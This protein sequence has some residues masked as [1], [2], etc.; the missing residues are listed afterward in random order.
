MR[1][2]KT[3]VAH[4]AGARPKRL[5]SR[6]GPRLLAAVMLPAL[7]LSAV[8]IAGMQRMNQDATA[9][10][11]VVAEVAQVERTLRLYAGLVDEKSGSES[12][13]IASAYNLS[14]AQV[15]RLT[16]F[17]V[18][19]Q[20]RTAR[21]AVDAALA[22]GGAAILGKHA[23]R[24]LPLRTRID[25]GTAPETAVRPYFINI[26]EVAQS[27]WLA[28]IRDLTQMSL[29]TVRAT[30][31]R[32]AIAGLADA[33]DAFLAG[34]RMTWASA[35]LT[36]QG[37]PGGKTGA[38]DLAAASALYARATSELGTELTGRGAATWH[39]LIAADADVKSFQRFLA[40]LRRQP[41]G[42]AAG[43]SIPEVART[44]RAGLIFQGHLRK[45]VDAAAVDVRTL[46]IRLHAAT[47]RDRNRY[48]LGLALVAACTA[49][50][51]FAIARSIVTPLRR[52]AAR[53]SEVSAG[54]IGDAPLEPSGPYEVALVTEAFNE[55][56]ANLV[57]LDTI[58]LAFADAHLDDPVLVNALPGRLGDSLRDS[59]ETLKESIR[60][61]A[62]LRENLQ[63]SETHFRDL[64][65]R[66]PD[67]VFRLTRDPAPRL[68]YL[69]PSF[70]DLT[71]ISV[72]SA[73]A[74]FGIV[75]AALDDLGRKVLADAA[76][77]RNFKPQVDITLRRKD[78]T[79]AV[80]E[81]H[82]VE[83]SDGIH[84]IGRD[85]TEIRALQAVLAEQ[86]MR[87]P[88][89]GLANRRF[90]DELLDRSL[91]R[92]RR[93]GTPIAVAFLDLDAFKSVNDN[94]GHEAGDTVLRVTAARLQAAVRDADVVARYGGDEFIVVYEGA[95]DDALQ[96][97]RQCIEDALELPVDI[98]NGVTVSCRPSVGIADSRVTHASAAE[99]ID[100]A[101]RAMLEAKRH[102]MHTPRPAV[103]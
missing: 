43:V 31:I 15:A 51:A 85:V 21:A 22:D 57:A 77:G 50:V 39:R 20:L 88:L 16:G 64:A 83:T 73:M 41:S 1:P 55:V 91:R 8:G 47:R 7:A 33:V 65:D 89:T 9:V 32:R 56:V 49:A 84:G 90:L 69:S 44:F 29:T 40:G 36:T 74:D 72:A 81:L 45:V 11:A 93:A 96:R 38:R 82:V 37:V 61:N 76:V 87:D 70:E 52:L 24:L 28:Q 58:T 53:A 27:A 48:L 13:V 78:G 54:A 98:G 10:S 101:D 19:G 68:E 2:G 94:Y 97:L 80:F 92:A 17:D 103:V 23:A 25:A 66:S 79:L 63:R 4:H 75:A 99:L 30:D 102:H 26:I 60:S 95:N 100:A 71:G 67:V 5:R 35:S 46:A 6:I 42:T 18:V 14:P 34:T 62:N 86:A 3:S 59:V 12:I